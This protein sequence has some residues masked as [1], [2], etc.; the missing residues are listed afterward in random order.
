MCYKKIKTIKVMLKK[1]ILICLLFLIVGTSAIQGQVLIGLLF[2]EK[3]NNEKLEF[4]LNLGVNFSQL[5]DVETNN[6][7][8]K[9][10]I[11]LFLD[12]KMHPKWVL[13]TSF[14]FMAPKGSTDL[15][16]NDLLFHVEDSLLG[17]VKAE[18]RINYFDLPV[19]ISYRP[20]P[21]IGV[22][23]GFNIA[24]VARTEDYFEKESNDGTL[25][26]HRGTRDFLSL[27]EA[28]ISGG[29]TWHFKGDPG[30]QIRVNYLYG[31][32]NVYKESTGK[33]GFNRVIQLSVLIP[34]KF[35]IGSK[36][37]EGND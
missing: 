37:E 32:T 25:I 13:Q 3:L 5:T 22:A 20:I 14:F 11:G 18:R 9:L 23:F 29:L 1:A 17:G 24:M 27:F 21:T 2:G 28:G 4:G 16:K 36:K 7:L 30:S 19:M 33:E 12:Y 6:Y 15:T 35:G 26:F 34:I 8:N 10:G 31:L